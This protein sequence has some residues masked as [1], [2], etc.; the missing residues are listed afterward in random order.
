MA[1]DSEKKTPERFDE[2]YKERRDHLL[3]RRHA[4]SVLLDKSLLTYSAGAFGISLA[5]LQ[6]LRRF[7]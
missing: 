3:E 7:I 4:Y 1:E 2:Q 5:F 6:D